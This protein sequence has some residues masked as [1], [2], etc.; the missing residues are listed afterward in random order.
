MS[1]RRFILLPLLLLP[2]L[3]WGQGECTPEPLPYFEDFQSG[4]VHDNGQGG[5]FWDETYQEVQSCWTVCWVRSFEWRSLMV[6]EYDNKVMELRS[7]CCYNMP[8]GRVY[9]RFAV[10]PRMA[11]EPRRL[12]FKARYFV[13]DYDRSHN[14]IDWTLEEG[15]RL[16]LG[17]VT[18]ENDCINTFTPFDTIRIDSNYGDYHINHP[19]MQ[20]FDIDLGRSFDTFPQPW[21]IAFRTVQPDSLAQIFIHIDDIRISNEQAEYHCTE[22]YVDTVCQDEGYHRHGFHIPPQRT[23][24]IGTRHYSYV[25]T[26]GCLVSLDLTVTGTH[27]TVLRDTV[28][29]GE[30]S[31]YMPDTSLTAGTHYFHLADRYGCDSLVVLTV[32]EA[33]VTHLYDTIQQGDTLLFE[34]RTLTANGTYRHDTVATDG[35]DSLVVMHLRVQPLPFVDV[36]TIVFWFPNVFTPSQEINK[37]FGC[38]TS[39]EVTEFEMYIYN[40]L[41]LLVYHTLDIGEWWDG[42]TLPQGAYVYHYRLR[43]AADNRV[44]S[45]V[46]TVLL[47]R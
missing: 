9:Y 40:R 26:T 44:R 45:G 10:S 3:A 37:R 17:Y 1:L 42:G 33:Y 8:P 24:D 31:H 23:L 29:C 15:G 16:A 11:A 32:D 2:C 41:G 25:D 43:T 46:G 22:H 7:Y 21:R 47:L 38:V 12:Q 19:P 14:D 28:P 20:L 4:F 13:P 35:C 34:G 6:L 36:D 30:S 27:T 5:S 39:C 18:D